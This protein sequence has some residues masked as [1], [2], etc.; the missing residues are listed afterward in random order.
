[1]FLGSLL[2]RRR[3]SCKSRNHRIGP[4]FRF[5]RIN[6]LMLRQV[7]KSFEH[8]LLAQTGHLHDIITLPEHGWS[9]DQVLQGSILQ[10]SVSAEFFLL[11]KNARYNFYLCI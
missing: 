10:N 11:Q 6:R 1:M 3:C 8:E 7:R 9:K 2:Q 5:L 4:R